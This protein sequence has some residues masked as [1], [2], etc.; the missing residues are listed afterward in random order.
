MSAWLLFFEKRASVV[1]EA[2]VVG[3]ERGKVL[4]LVMTELHF[5]VEL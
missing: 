5:F 1:C 4:L 3:L 2:M